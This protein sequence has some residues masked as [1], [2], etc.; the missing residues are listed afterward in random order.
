[1]STAILRLSDNG[2]RLYEARRSDSHGS[3][4]AAV[5]SG[6]KR[7]YVDGTHLRRAS[8][9]YVQRTERPRPDELY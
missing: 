7:I 1:V 3:D 6:K 9:A 5:E 2:R 8:A 4:S